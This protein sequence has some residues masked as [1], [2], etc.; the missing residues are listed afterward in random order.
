MVI[1]IIS[2]N[3]YSSSGRQVLVTLKINSDV[4]L[5]KKKKKKLINVKRKSR[6]HSKPR[7]L[8]TQ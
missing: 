7:A 4:L 6:K 8:L 1:Y 2:F 3:P 5:I